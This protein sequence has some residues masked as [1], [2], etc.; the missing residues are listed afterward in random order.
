LT[1]E[2]TARPACSSRAVL[3]INVA[4]STRDVGRGMG[5]KSGLSSAAW[6]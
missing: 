5:Y 3:I 4:A 6:F 2:T 1:R